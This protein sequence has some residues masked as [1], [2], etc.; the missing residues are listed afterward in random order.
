MM[1][2][3]SFQKW[4]SKSVVLEATLIGQACTVGPRG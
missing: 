2:P 4:Q 3:P 1:L